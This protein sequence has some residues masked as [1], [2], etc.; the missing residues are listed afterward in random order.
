GSAH[1]R[2]GASGMI[3]VAIAQLGS[4]GPIMPTSWY[5]PGAPISTAPPTSPR[6]PRLPVVAVSHVMPVVLAIVDSPLRSWFTSVDADD[7]APKPASVITVP[8]AGVVYAIGTGV[9][10]AGASEASST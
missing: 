5:E 10:D 2:T 1:A 6:Q 9:A 4:L 3:G 8:T 7:V